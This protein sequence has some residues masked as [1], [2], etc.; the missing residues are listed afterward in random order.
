MP[1]YVQF[2]LQESREWV[3]LVGDVI[4]LKVGFECCSVEFGF[5]RIASQC[6]FVEAQVHMSAFYN[7]LDFVDLGLYV[8][9]VV[10]EDGQVV[11]VSCGGASGSG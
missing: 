10:D 11:C 8:V 3:L 2:V 4:R 5:V 1:K 9:I 6:T 7:F